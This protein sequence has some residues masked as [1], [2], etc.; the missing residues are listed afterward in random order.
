MFLAGRKPPHCQV[1]HFILSVEVCCDD[2]VG[3]DKLLVRLPPDAGGFPRLTVLPTFRV[4]NQFHS[5]D[6]AQQL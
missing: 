5:Q 2:K 3:G 4:I 6:L 1:H